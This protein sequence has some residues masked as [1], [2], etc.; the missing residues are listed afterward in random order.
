MRVEAINPV[1]KDRQPI[2]EKA[3][4]KVRK[5]RKVGNF[6]EVLKVERRKLEGR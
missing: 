2:Q 3:V 1:N 5:V 6:G 4:R